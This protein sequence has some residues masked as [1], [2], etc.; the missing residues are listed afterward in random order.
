[1]N[2]KNDVYEADEIKAVCD[3]LKT[4]KNITG[5][6]ETSGVTTIT[7]NSLVLLNIVCPIYLQTGQ[8]VTINSINYQVSNVNQTLLTFDIEATNLVATKWNLAINFKFGTRIEINQILDTE[9]KD[10]TKKNIRFPLI[11]LFVN[12]SRDHD[13][14]EY[15]YKTNLKM[16]IVHLSRP[17]YK[18]EYRKDNIFKKILQPLETLLLEAIRSPYFSEVFNWEYMEFKYIDYYRYFYGSS[19]K[20]ERVFDAVTD[21][22]EV[23]LDITFQNQY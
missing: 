14:I 7:T 17:E 23:D 10:S 15:D 12:E 6:S 22:I 1:M 18:A 5:I 4:E 11:W 16:A 3:F 8:I 9:S 13:S 2:R 20:N 19:D 21:A